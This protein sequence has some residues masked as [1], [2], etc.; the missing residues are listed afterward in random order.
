MYLVL[1]ASLLG[2]IL[3]SV[4]EPLKISFDCNT[5]PQTL[6]SLSSVTLFAASITVANNLPSLARLLTL[7]N[8]YLRDSLEL[9]CSEWTL[10]TLAIVKKHCLNDLSAELLFFTRGCIQRLKSNIVSPLFED[11]ILNPPPDKSKEPQYLLH[12]EQIEPRGLWW[13]EYSRHVDWRDVI[14]RVP[15]YIDGP[16][17]RVGMLDLLQQHVDWNQLVE[18][19][20]RMFHSACGD[21][22]KEIWS[23][24]ALMRLQLLLPPTAGL[25][26]AA[27]YLQE[28]F[29]L[30]GHTKDF[31]T[32]A[33]VVD[34]WL[35][36]FVLNQSYAPAMLRTMIDG[37]R[38]ILLEAESYVLMNILILI[39]FGSPNFDENDR[40]GLINRILST[41]RQL[42]DFDLSNFLWHASSYAPCLADKGCLDRLAGDDLI[43]RRLMSTAPFRR[44]KWTS[45]L[46]PTDMARNYFRRWLIRPINSNDAVSLAGACSDE[47][48][49]DIVVRV[50]WN[51]FIPLPSG[52]LKRVL[53]SVL[54]AHPHLFT[55]TRSLDSRLVLV[56]TAHVSLVD[57]PSAAL[58]RGAVELLLRIQLFFA[59][60]DSSETVMYRLDPK[61]IQQFSDA[62][63]IPIMSLNVLYPHFLDANSVYHTH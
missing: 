54:D 5:I 10:D 4:I 36:A 62:Y 17:F 20:F 37:H 63:L 43:R 3:F 34:L 29:K 21:P 42:D 30:Y 6:P 9:T 1:S 46:M 49:F 38:A 15:E 18:V 12:K 8:V 44:N 52:T 33:S 22:K 27:V 55:R 53:Q 51:C 60:E 31:G 23:L 7:G 2:F 16:I 45:I 56:N 19:Y 32:V 47:A 11:L 14:R 39:V 26:P 41:L 40:Q 57:S 24:Y 61:T 28:L 48:V 35:T 50:P 58:V 13:P 25:N 59:D